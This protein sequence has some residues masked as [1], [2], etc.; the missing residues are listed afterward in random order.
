MIGID[1]NTGKMIGGVEH[2][3]QSLQDLLT[4]PK[5]TRIMRADYGS[6]IPRLV[7][8]PVNA[9]T[10]VDI[11]AESAGAIMKWEK[12]FSVS[13]VRVTTYTSSSVELAISGRYLPDGTDVTLEGIVVK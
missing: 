11:I 1:R 6:E 12:R 2:L 13:E 8:M 3:R 10:L 5:G 7:D 9:D 4:T